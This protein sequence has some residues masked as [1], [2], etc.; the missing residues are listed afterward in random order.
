MHCSART[1]PSS[2]SRPTRN[3][4]PQVEMIVDYVES[5][6]LAHCFVIN[7]LDRPGADFVGTYAALRQRFGNHVV[8]EQAPIGQGENLSGLRRRGRE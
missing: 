8:A 4:L 7:R 5:L 6:S 2:W 3:R 1:P